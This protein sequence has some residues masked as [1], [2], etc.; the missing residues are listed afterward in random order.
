MML[1]YLLLLVVSLTFYWVGKRFTYW[2]QRGVPF[3]EP[4]FPFGNLGGMSK[5]HLGP[6]VQDSYNKLIG[7][8]KKFG[9]IFFFVSPVALILDLDFAKD[10]LVKDFQYFH[11]RGVYHNEKT[12]PLRVHLVSMEGAKWKRLRSKLTPTFS[13][14]KMKMM[15]PTIIAVAEQFQRCLQVEAEKSG[16][17]DIK[18]FLARYTTDVIGNCA[19]GLECNSLKDPDAEFRR[20]GKKALS[21]TFGGFL[22]QLLS[23]TFSDLARTIGVKLTDPDVERFFMD[24]VRDTISFREKNNVERNDFM[25]LLIKLQRPQPDDDNGTTTEGLT[26]NEIAAQAFVFF[27]AGFE[28][29]STAM[30]YCLYE[31]ALNQELQDKARQNVNEVLGRHGSMSYEAVHEMRYVE[32]CI[33]ESLRKYPPIVNI[34]REI[35]KDYRVPDMNVTLEKGNTIILPIYS[36]HHD[37]RYYPEPEK[38]NPDRFDPEGT[39]KRHPLAFVPFGE[40]PRVCIGLRFGMMQARIGL[41]CLLKHFRFTL[42]PK[43]PNPLKIRAASTILSSE[44]GLWMRVEKI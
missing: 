2:K 11:D 31:L 23:G 39:A 19:F 26:F 37:P 6:L 18:E 8:G 1:L 13:S 38:Y 44:G 12:D 42:S 9:G 25:D 35:S 15:F 41:A 17:L 16:E 21:I 20:M 28:T 29:S 4:S 43:T 10:V 3:V 5:R 14:G 22:R 36:I 32:N 27:L 40:G 33:N 30:S 7:S 34:P 24:A